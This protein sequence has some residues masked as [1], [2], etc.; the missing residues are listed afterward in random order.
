MSDIEKFL[1]HEKEAR[2]YDLTFT[3]QNGTQIPKASISALTLTLFLK[4]SSPLSYINS[5]NAL[6]ALDANGVTIDTAG[7]ITYA[8]QVADLAIA[9]TGAEVEVHVAV[10]HLTTTGGT[11][12]QVRKEIYFYIDNLE[13]I[14][15]VGAVAPTAPIT[16]YFYKEFTVTG[17]VAA[18]QQVNYSTLGPSVT[19][20]IPPSAFVQPII[21]ILNVRQ[22]RDVFVTEI[23]ATYFKLAA[24]DA[25]VDGTVK[26]DFLLREVG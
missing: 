2:F 1:V 19:G 25:G 24:S 9:N 14:D 10:F 26:V 3:D 17:T 4:D 11:P 5:R 16:E 13:H 22:D 21:E 23:A 20:S 8:V 6:N 15:A 12:I 18:P 7:K